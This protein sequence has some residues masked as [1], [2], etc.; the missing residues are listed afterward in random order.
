[1][2]TPN[3]ALPSIILTVAHVCSDEGVRTVRCRGS[4]RLTMFYYGVI[5]GGVQGEGVP[6]APG[7]PRGALGNTGE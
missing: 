2:F 7:K 1:M 5:K 6:K 4:C 3:L